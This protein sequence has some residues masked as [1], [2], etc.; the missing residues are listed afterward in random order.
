MGVQSLPSSA[1]SAVRVSLATAGLAA[2]P[3]L[4]SLYSAKPSSCSRAK[5]AN[6]SGAA[7]SNAAA[8]LADLVINPSSGANRQPDSFASAGTA[9]LPLLTDTQTGVLPVKLQLAR[10]W[11]SSGKGF[12]L[13]L[14]PLLLVSYMIAA[15]EPAE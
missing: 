5:P 8:F 12:T 9:E 3:R 13:P 10:G 15:R 1:I 2:A 7:A 11:P 6:C 4:Y 14:C